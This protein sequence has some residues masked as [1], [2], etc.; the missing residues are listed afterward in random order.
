MRT[1]TALHLPIISSAASAVRVQDG[2]TLP[3][4]SWW[5]SCQWV[6]PS[7]TVMGSAMLK[8][9][10]GVRERCFVVVVFAWVGRQVE[11]KMRNKKRWGFVGI[12][13]MRSV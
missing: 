9:F 5:V 3:E 4:Y 7:G 11:R 2:E 12:L 13:L 1:R 8:E 6:M 10:T